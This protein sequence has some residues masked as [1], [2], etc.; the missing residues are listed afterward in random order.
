MKLRYLAITIFTVLISFHAIA[1]TF[2]TDSKKP[3]F[4]QLA[5]NN[6]AGT[7][8]NTP[9]QGQTAGGEHQM[10]VVDQGGN[11]RM[12]SPSSNPPPSVE[13]TQPPAHNNVTSPG[14]MQM[15]P[16]AAG[17]PGTG[18]QPVQRQAPM[19]NQNFQLSPVTPGG[20]PNQATP[21]QTPL[22]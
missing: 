6:V 13:G 20:P 7:P 9:V 22:H 10:T 1:G 15:S 3:G 11:L 19:P 8:P 18:M 5:E 2:Q 12:A 14:M 17:V 4:D 21:T 16:G